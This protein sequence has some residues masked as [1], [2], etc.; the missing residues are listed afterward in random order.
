M[1]GKFGMAAAMAAELSKDGLHPV[2]AWEIAVRAVF[3]DS[4]ASQ[5]KGCPKSAF[6]GLAEA[7]LVLGVPAGQYTTSIE[8]KSYAAAAVQMLRR[9][10]QLAQN[11]LMLW[12]RVMNGR[13]KRHNGQMDVVIALLSTGRL[14]GTA[15][16]ARP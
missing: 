14:V 10:P 1:Y 9:E 6:L 4:P 2:K 13:D 12:R 15:Q 3:P 16:T 5:Y 8:N 7:G 11:P